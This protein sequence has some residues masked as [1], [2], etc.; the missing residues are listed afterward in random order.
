MSFFYEKILFKPGCHMQLKPK[1]LNIS[2]YISYRLKQ[3]IS[4]A[5]DNR[6]RILKNKNA[7]PGLAIQNRSKKFQDNRLGTN[8]RETKK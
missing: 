1:Q 8:I 5:C 2:V 3:I 7:S 4:V 6:D